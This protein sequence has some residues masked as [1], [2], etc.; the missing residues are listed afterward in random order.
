MATAE[1]KAPDGRR[2]SRNEDFFGAEGQHKIAASGVAIVGL[3][4]LGSHVTQQLGYLGTQQFVL[5][6]HDHISESSLNRVV[7]ADDA[8][9]AARKLKID[10]GKRRLLAIN[11]AAEIETLPVMLNDDAAYKAI[12]KANVVFGCVDNDLARVQL[13]RI[14][15]E[16]AIPLID[17]ATDVDPKAN[18]MTYGGRVVCCTGDGCLVCLN[19]LDQRAL[20]LAGM[21]DEQAEAYERI[22]GVSREALGQTGPMVVSINGVVA[23]LAVTEFIALITGLRPVNRQ[24]AYHGHSTLIRHSADVPLADCYYCRGLWGTAART[25]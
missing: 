16:L 7:T 24:V 25:A 23:S 12:A 10:A 4:G 2:Y 6:D 18:P 21:T 9:I 19:V 8:D 20:A 13:T 14:C 11:P 3:G 5:I 1:D 17:L 22:Y 15:S